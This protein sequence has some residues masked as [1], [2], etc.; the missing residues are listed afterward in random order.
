MPREIHEVENIEGGLHGPSA[1]ALTD[2]VAPLRPPI[3]SSHS[4]T[5]I[6]AD[7]ERQLGALREPT[8]KCQDIITQL[9]AEHG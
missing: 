1:K 3:L 7:A 8:R 6:L 9:D 5:A 4:D 2:Q